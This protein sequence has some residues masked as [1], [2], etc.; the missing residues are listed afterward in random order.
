MVCDGEKRVCCINYTR[1]A[2]VHRT[3]NR[4]EMVWHAIVIQDQ[5]GVAVAAPGEI[6]LVTLDDVNVAPKLV[7]SSMGATLRPDKR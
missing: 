4:T 3:G 6:P 2:L 7:S 5:I 1:S